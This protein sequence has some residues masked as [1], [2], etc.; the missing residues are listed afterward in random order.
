MKLYAIPTLKELEEF[1]ECSGKWNLAFEYN[2]FF[3]PETL[4][5]P[6]KTKEIIEIYKSLDRDRSEDTLHGA[7]LDIVVNS[8]DPEI[9]EISKKRV[10]QCM[11][12]AR[13]LGVRAVIFHTN[14]I[15]NFRLE[16]YKKCWAERNE[17]FWR[18]VLLDYP[19]LSV[20]MEN[21]FDDSPDMLAALAEKM[22]D[23]ERFGVCLDFAHAF[24]SGT[25]VAVWVDKLH[26]YIRHIHINDNNGLEDTHFPVGQ[27]S[28]PWENYKI[29]LKKIERDPSV[30]IEVRGV[31][32]LK[33][34]L[35]FM[36]EKGLL[37]DK[38]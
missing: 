9:Y 2:D 38:C 3:V 25:P 22:A 19:D 5:N 7:F 29:W 34:S 23:E 35:Q 10:Y 36:N 11:E 30:L 8:E 26:P 14:Y 13:E 12:I 31:K 32:A 6:E 18:N 1:C 17:A 4:M 21:M 27:G 20:Y 24:I 15:V 16:Y 37:E 28:F 33:E